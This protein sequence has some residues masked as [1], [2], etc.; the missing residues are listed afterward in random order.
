LVPVEASKLTGNL[1]CE[2]RCGTIIDWNLCF[3]ADGTTSARSFRS[4]T[5]AFMAPVLLDDKPISRRTLAHDM[6]SYFAVIIWIASLNYED[7]VAFQAKPLIKVLLNKSPEDI[8]QYK[9]HWFS[10]PQFFKAEI[11]D[12]FEQPY[13]ADIQFLLCLSELCD[14]LYP[15]EED[16]DM[17]ALLLG[18]LDKNNSEETGDADP[19]KEG[20]FRKC[21]GAIDSYLGD[22]KGCQEIQW[23]DDRASPHISESLSQ[24]GSASN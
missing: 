3:K 9:H 7:E 6:E 5:Q 13:L 1:T 17:K 11:I 8:V 16:I 10:S 21:M 22:S 14:I 19:M 15:R 20:L 18:K 12:H 23:I 24:G 4:G 2:D